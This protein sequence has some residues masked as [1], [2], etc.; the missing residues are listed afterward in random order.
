VRVQAPA[1]GFVVLAD[2]Y[3]PGWRAMVDGAEARLLRANYSM[4]AVPVPE[5]VHEVRFRYEPRL[6]YLG[7]GVSLATTLMI[8]LLLL[9][10]SRAPR[11]PAPPDRPEPSSAAGG[12]PW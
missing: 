12:N 3:Y 1:S 2:T 6:L 8:A 7:A 11:E 10:G 4:R 5:G 9:R